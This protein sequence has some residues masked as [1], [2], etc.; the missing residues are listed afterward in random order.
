MKYK[1]ST[2]FLFAF[3]F[4]FN[5]SCSSSKRNSMELL[6]ISKSQKEILDQKID[7]FNDNVLSK[8][9]ELRDYQ[10]R[11]VE[12]IFCTHTIV[13]IRKEKPPSRIITITAKLVCAEPSSNLSSMKGKFGD[14]AKNYAGLTNLSAF[15]VKYFIIKSDKNIFSVSSFQLPRPNPFYLS[16]TSLYFTDKEVE[17]INSTELNNKVA[18]Q[19]LRKKLEIFSQNKNLNGNK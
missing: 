16:D 12:R 8:I 15:P 3:L 11:K 5:T 4:F 9:I 6:D 19:K 18:S 1:I 14:D 17:K 2:F 7:I 10:F 13:E